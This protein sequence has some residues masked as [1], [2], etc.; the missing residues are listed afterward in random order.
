MRSNNFKSLPDLTTTPQGRTTTPTEE[1]K[2]VKKKSSG[3][4]GADAKRENKRLRNN[5][6]KEL[7]KPGQSKLLL[8]VPEISN[9]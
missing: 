3:M 8:F 9:I 6:T 2:T 1:T 7:R 5:I 4:G